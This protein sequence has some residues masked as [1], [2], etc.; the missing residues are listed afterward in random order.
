MGKVL[1][2]AVLG[3]VILFIWSSMSWMVLPWHNNTFLGFSNEAVVSQAMLAGS[4]KP[5]VYLTPNMHDG[6]GDDSQM[7]KYT[8]PFALIIWNREGWGDMGHKML[9]AFVGDVLAAL[10][11]ALLLSLATIRSFG[12]RVLFVALLGLFAGVSVHLS[13]FI[14]WGFSKD[15]TLVAVADLFIAW[16]LAGLALAKLNTGR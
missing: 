11:A 1:L 16:L 10:V 7:G 13:N 3:G 14:W 6:K 15:F 5:G 8:G 2:S 4:E 9:F 12:K